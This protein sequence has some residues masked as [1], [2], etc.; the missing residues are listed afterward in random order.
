MII[1]GFALCLLTASPFYFL[2][3]QCTDPCSG[4]L[5]LNG[6]FEQVQDPACSGGQ[7][8]GQL[9]LDGTSAA[10]WFGAI[11]STS[12][13]NI[14]T[15]DY[16]NDN[17]ASHQ[18]EGN[19]GGNG[20][21]GFFSVT[22]PGDNSSEWVQ[23]Q[24]SQPLEAGK[25]YC[26]TFSAFSRASVGAG[27]GL[28]VF[29]LNSSFNQDVVG[30]NPPFAPAYSNPSG[31]I[32]PTSCSTYTFDYCA[33]GGESWIAFGNQDADQTQ[34]SPPNIQ[35]YVIVDNISLVEVCGATPELTV[36]AT[37]ETV[38]CGDCS[39]VSATL[40]NAPAGTTINWTPNIGSGT[41]PF[42]VCPTE[43]T[44]Y[45]ASATIIGCSGQPTI[46]TDQVVVTVDCND[47]DVAL[48]L[49]DNQ[50]CAGECV[51]LS[52]TTTSSQPLSYSWSVAGFSGAGPFSDCPLST[53][54]YSVTATDGSG[55][56]ATATGTV[57]VL[58]NPQISIPQIGPFCTGDGFQV[59]TATPAGGIWSGDIGAGGDIDVNG[60][61]AGTYTASY[62]FT[63]GNG[64]SSSQAVS[65]EILDV[66]AAAFV[67]PPAAV[68]A[69]EAPFAL[70]ITPAGLGGPFSGPGVDPNTGVFDP[71]AA[72]AGVQTITYS[73]GAGSCAAQISTQIEVF[74]NPIVTVSPIGPFCVGDGIQ[75]AT[76]TPPGGTWS[77]NIAPSGDIDVDGL[78]AGTYTAKYLFTDGNGCSTSEPRD[79]EILQPV[80]VSFVNFP[81]AICE[82]A[83]LVPIEVSPAGLDGSFSGPGVEASTA[84]FDPA[85]AGAGMHTITFSYEAGGCPGEVSTQITVWEDPVVEVT[86]IGPFCTGDS[87]QLATASPMGGF[88][89]GDVSSAG[90]INVD[91]LGAGSYTA[92]YSVVSDEGCATSQTVSF[93]ILEAIPVAFTNP[94]NAVCIDE[95][96]FDLEVTPA[97]LAGTFSGSEGLSATGVFNP[98]LS[99]PGL[100][101]ITY[102][103]G[104]G[105][106]AGEVSVDILVNELPVVSLPPIGPF[107]EN[108]D[109]QFVTVTP[110]N[111]SWSGAIGEDGEIDVA[112]LAP[113]FY[114]V[115]YTVSEGA[116]STTLSQSFEITPEPEL[117][118][119]NN[120]RQV[121]LGSDAFALKV[122]SSVAALK[123]DG[124]GIVDSLQGIFDPAVA[125]IGL[126]DLVVSAGT[127]NC[128]A[129][130][131]WTLR[132]VN[133][134]YVPNAFS[135]NGD[136]INDMFLVYGPQIEDGTLTVYDRWGEQIFQTQQPLTTGWDGTF[137]GEPMNPAVFVWVLQVNNGSDLTL[138]EKGEVTLI[139]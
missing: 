74:A 59:A 136:G 19:C 49:S 102:S 62:T 18:S 8:A 106:C 55:N 85:A 67:N 72:G 31:S 82:D 13:N 79:F 119:E 56:S 129:Q 65:F 12:F 22:F 26:I 68:C 89:S 99:G 132:V 27:D 29:I 107:C 109:I 110:A 114:T 137:K 69:D 122:A 83:A 76:A 45:E 64:C 97:G 111:G 103:Y 90:I 84:L 96:P 98:T 43:T 93:D 40:N 52:A 91:S 20:A 34:V 23:G 2:S 4:N 14:Y 61:G 1:R 51:T 36:A 73:Y 131:F 47:V 128:T 130:A 78:G 38:D 54:T 115:D 6:D 120:P 15:P 127:G 11:N 32:I 66:P 17:C 33:Q 63:D 7:F 41:G 125:G 35:A 117:V 24:L 139:R 95:A 104:A 126:H 138:I 57:I 113:G 121:K 58:P 116:C 105:S 25:E 81:Q 75:V 71:S 124:P 30:L 100:Q 37:P 86:P 60:L 94:P 101:S 10:S 133:D 50:I 9:Y 42:T 44:T 53:T 123:F 21:V 87:L 39:T 70:E 48:N 5:V 108:D 134:W 112:G 118:F 88:W 16:F 92:M 3:A 77:G 80:S 46:I 135:P 28:D